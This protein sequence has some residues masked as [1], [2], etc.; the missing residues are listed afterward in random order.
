MDLRGRK[1]RLRPSLIDVRGTLI[2][3]GRLRGAELV[4]LRIGGELVNVVV[5]GVDI[6]PL[7]EAE[8]NRRMPDRAKMKPTDSAG[9]RTAWTILEGLWTDTVA[10]AR[11]FPAADLHRGVDGQDDPGQRVA[12]ASL[13]HAVGRGARLGRHPVGPLGPATAGRGT[14]RTREASG[15]GPRR[16]RIARRPACRERDQHRTRLAALSNVD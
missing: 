14:G 15:D 12:V 4:D 3:G 16:H 9:F 8:L 2:E 13:G 1:G 5:N 7:V 6:G 10:R 11:T